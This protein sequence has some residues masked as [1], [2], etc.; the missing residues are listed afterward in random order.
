MKRMN[1][2]ILFFS[3]FLLG[4]A[5]SSLYS[6]INFGS[7]ESAIKVSSGAKLNVGSPGLTIDG[8]LDLSSAWNTALTLGDASSIY[9]P[10]FTA[11]GASGHWTFP[12]TSHINGN[13]ETLDLSAG[14]QITIGAGQ[15]LY[16]DDMVI[17][18]LG[19]GKGR[20]NFGS[21]TSELHLSN[22][23]L[24]IDTSVAIASGKVFIDSQSTI[25]LKGNTLTFN[26]SGKLIVEGTVLWLEQLDQVTQGT[27]RF[28]GN[29]DIYDANGFNQINTTAAISAGFL[30]LNNNAL[31]KKTAA[32]SNLDAEEQAL[33]SGNLSTSVNLSRNLTIEQGRGINVNG[34]ITIN[35]NGATIA[36]SEGEQ[37]IIADGKTLTLSN[38]VL[39]KLRNSTI[40]FGQN[41]HL[42]FG[43]NVT[44]ELFEDVTFTSNTVGPTI[45]PLV[46]VL[47]SLEGANTVK[48]RGLSGKRTLEFVTPTTP[49]YI[50]QRPIQMQDNIL[51]FES[52]ICKGLDAS[53]LTP[54][55]DAAA[56]VEFPEVDLLGD[57]MLVMSGKKKIEDSLTENSSVNAVK[58]KTSIDIFVEGEN[59]TLKLS[60]DGINY[61]GLITYG[62]KPIN[63]LHVTFDAQELSDGRTTLPNRKGSAINDKYPYLTLSGTGI[64]LYCP[65]IEGSDP[66]IAIGIA[67]LR[68]DNDNAAI[69]I[70]DPNSFQI[71]TGSEL[72]FTNLQLVGNA[73]NQNSVNVIIGGTGS[74]LSGAIDTTGVRL[75]RKGARN[76][77]KD[78]KKKHILELEKLQAIET[79]GEQELLDLV[80]AGLTKDL[81]IDDLPV[82]RTLSLSATFDRPTI[83]NVY[84]DLKKTFNGNLAYD[85]ST[86]TNFTTF[87]GTGALAGDYKPF[88]LVLEKNNK[89]FLA[90]ANMKLNRLPNRVDSQLI[91]VR[92][93]GNE[94]YVNR[95]FTFKSNLFMDEGAELTFVFVDDGKAIPTIVFDTNCLL[96][97]EKNATLRFKGQG[98]VIL[99]NGVLVY[100]RGDV[101]TSINRVGFATNKPRFILTDGA[102]LDF[103]S[104]ATANFAGFGTIEINNGGMIAPSSVCNF[105]I[106]APQTYI[107]PQDSTKEPTYTAIASPSYSKLDDFDIIVKNNGEIRLDLPAALATTLGA[108]WA[109]KARI[110]IQYATTSI[111]FG[112]GG[113]LTVGNNALLDI[114]ADT[115]AA[116]VDASRLK[117]G[118]IRSISFG[119]NGILFIKPTGKLALGA[120]ALS[121]ITDTTGL[122]WNGQQLLKGQEMPF[123]WFASQAQMGGAGSVHC[124]AKA[125]KNDVLGTFAP[126]K[127]AL[128]I[129]DTHLVAKEL[130]TLMKS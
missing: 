93:T 65:I 108:D 78:R 100:F 99:S 87:S 128:F 127:A 112:Q 81:K 30:F 114:N 50:V 113:M 121:P 84:E 83:V 118:R 62:S 125:A 61:G 101:D 20:I 52:I 63:E 64:G 40:R 34:N 21:A 36:F 22:V 29:L 107:K 88:N 19:T 95:T 23:T 105:N 15:K 4:T 25:V 8:V 17:Q 31:I 69:E 12:G 123:S 124:P 85:G 98:R 27:L 60:R 55:V 75:F 86:L 117:P 77:I 51:S 115:R 37:I 126:T 89:V 10:G 5:V 74:N 11:L 73:L 72:L 16:L 79:K 44:L 48:V 47:N 92:G 2:S 7:R 49:R 80:S 32:Q 76:T 67:R 102:T 56:I 39:N 97:L 91:N 26:A 104:K 28:D 70:L 18:G 130:I 9:L 58:P 129:D 106:G 43:D 120:S 3:F 1:I 90:D 24:V 6:N 71:D 122:L 111:L 38:V 110:G 103:V 82:T 94:I 66:V 116:F 41:A 42:R 119:Y 33:I 59:N 96:E 109:L 57:S 13:G 45:T 46:E 68:F 54:G 35:G 14:G 53:V